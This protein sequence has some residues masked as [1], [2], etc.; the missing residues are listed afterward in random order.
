MP[1]ETL[2]PDR[3]PEILSVVEKI[4]QRL[5]RMEESAQRGDTSGSDQEAR[6]LETS[7]LRAALERNT[8]AIEAL[9]SLM[10]Q[11]G[12]GGDF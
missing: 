4:E 12:T 2:Q 3:L 5:T 6:R 1:D 11:N 7:L 9:T 8:E 10:Q